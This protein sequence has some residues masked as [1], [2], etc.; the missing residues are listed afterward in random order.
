MGA[1]GRLLLSGGA[2]QTIQTGQAAFE[3]SPLFYLLLQEC[4][5]CRI[6]T[7]GFVEQRVRASLV[8][9]HCDEV[10]RALVA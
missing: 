3:I 7:D 10:A 1:H 4:L 9:A 8:S 2:E 5:E 6:H